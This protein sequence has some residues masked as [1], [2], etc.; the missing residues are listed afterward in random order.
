MGEG[1]GITEEEMYLLLFD[2]VSGGSDTTSKTVEWALCELMRHPAVL[3]QL[4]AELEAY[5]AG[6][7]P[8]A[9]LDDV[10]KLP[11]LQVRAGCRG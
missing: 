8:A 11:Y 9:A 4:K 10:V 7:G 5:H 1:A 2:M 3:E 6:S